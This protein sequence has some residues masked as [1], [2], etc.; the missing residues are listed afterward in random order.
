[1]KEQKA[2]QRFQLVSIGFHYV[3]LFLFQENINTFFKLCRVS[4]FLSTC[5]RVSSRT[6]SVFSFSSDCF[7]QIFDAF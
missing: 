3:K 2:I 4:Y 7:V 5:Y 6:G 1:M